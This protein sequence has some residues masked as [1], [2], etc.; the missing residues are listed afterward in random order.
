MKV[1]LTCLVLSFIFGSLGKA[2]RVEV[3]SY[4]ITDVLTQRRLSLFLS[5]DKIVYKPN[6]RVYWRAIVTSAFGLFP[7]LGV[8]L[9]ASTVQLISPG[10]DVCFQ[11]PAHIFGN[12]LSGSWKIP[13]HQNGGQYIIRVQPDNS[14]MMPAERNIEIRSQLESS[15]RL[16]IEIEF[17]NK[18]FGP[19]DKVV[20]SVQVKRTEGGYPSFADFKA[21]AF[22]GGVNIFQENSALDEFGLGVVQFTI[23]QEIDSDE[24]VLMVT[25]GDG[26]IEVK[27]KTIPLLAK[28]LDI[29]FFPEGGK[30]ISGVEN[31][32]YF[33]ALTNTAEPVDIIATLIETDPENS[34]KK[35]VGETVVSVHEGRGT[36]KFV[37]SNGRMYQLE[38][39]KP[40]GVYPA[41]LPLSHLFGVVLSTTSPAFEADQDIT[42]TVE[43][44][45]D[46]CGTKHSLTLAIKDIELAREDVVLMCKEKTQVVFK[47]VPTGISGVLRVTVWEAETN[48]P[49]SERLIFRKPSETLNIEISTNPYFKQPKNID[50][51]PGDEVELFVRVTNTNGEKIPAVLSI[52]VVDN[53]VLSLIEK[54]KRHPNLPTMVYL[55]KEVLH[56]EDPEKYFSSDKLADTAIDLLLGTQGWRTF[57]FLEDSE[58]STK[59]K[60]C[61]AHDCPKLDLHHYEK[62]ADVEF[63]D[64]QD[65]L[66]GMIS[67]K[68]SI[69]ALVVRFGFKII[70][71]FFVLH[72]CAIF[73]V[74]IIIIDFRWLFKYC[75]Y[76]W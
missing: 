76:L 59:L 28:E 75:H 21:T 43:P 41:V 50:F 67:R 26:A 54:R 73:V 39:T 63:M 31:K 27:G 65:K 48:T 6:E 30:L 69:N 47:A 35:V 34:F 60:G 32:V 61:K 19:G 15:S 2:E 42:V 58:D 68:V 66:L 33:E 13:P 25:V 62:F 10:G 16:D 52:K 57:V 5:T 56:L 55:E 11:E 9:I 38:F 53:M 7:H 4:N 51:S 29:K 40:S 14:A 1:F 12:V 64:S 49:V 45:P 71:S 23:P 36:F 70:I 44:S 8:P 74:T 18:G 24:G 37:P 17:V 3:E 22:I 72:L 20:A 46:I